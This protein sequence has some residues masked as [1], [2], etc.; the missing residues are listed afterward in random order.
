[1]WAHD[2]TLWKPSPQDDVELS[3]RL[4]WLTLPDDF[5]QAARLHELESLAQLAV[6]EGIR[7]VVVCG[8]GG[9]SLAPEVFN[10]TFGHAEGCPQLVV[11]DSTDPTRVRMVDGIIDPQH[12]FF[13]ISSK[14]GGTLEVMSFLAHFWQSTGGQGGASSRSP[15]QTPVSID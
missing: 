8:M 13:L 1:M 15:T 6:K 9:S 12:T 11:L 10:L 14:S 2:P 3:N 5:Q 4:G 7:H